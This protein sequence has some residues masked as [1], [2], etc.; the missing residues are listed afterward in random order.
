LKAVDI[1]EVRQVARLASNYHGLCIVL[2]THPHPRVF[3]F[4]NLDERE[5]FINVFFHAQKHVLS[6][7]GYG[8]AQSNVNRLS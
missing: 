8:K 5:R 3:I 7:R 1:R 4:R 6:L 2:A